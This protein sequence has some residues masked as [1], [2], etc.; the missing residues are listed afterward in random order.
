ME[1]M[2]QK[3]FVVTK[4]TAMFR[5]TIVVSARYS[6]T[7]LYLTVLLRTADPVS[8]KRISRRLLPAQASCSA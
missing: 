3:T 2:T 8:F 1:R 7:G 4:C 6:T 5:E